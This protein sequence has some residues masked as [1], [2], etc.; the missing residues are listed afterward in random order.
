MKF[1]DGNGVATLWAK[2]KSHV[3]DKL[4]EHVDNIK[5]RPNGLATLNQEG[6]LDENQLPPFKTINGQSVQGSGNIEID[7]E[8]YEVVTSLPTSNI[9]TNKI[10][11]IV[12]SDGV[13]TNEYEEYLYVNNKWEQVGKYKA[14]VDL[15]PYVK[16][17]DIVSTTENG[18]MSKEDKV[19][20]NGIDTNATCD[21]S[22][23][24]TELDTILT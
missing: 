20:L 8:L 23:S 10:Y 9:K 21:S 4:Q 1:L 12:D 18:I 11:L 7:V 3:Q 17:S 14:N 5:G 19:K 13:N 16:K 2:I 22:I 24:S 15:T 6:Q